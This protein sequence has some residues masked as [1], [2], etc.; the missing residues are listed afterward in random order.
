MNNIPAKLKILWLID[1]DYKAG[2][3][4]GGNLRYFNFSRELISKG[5]EVYFIFNENDPDNIEEKKKFLQILIEKKAVTDY[6]EIDYKHPRP[7]KDIICLHPIIANRLQQKKQKSMKD[8]IIK[9]IKNKKIDIFILSDRPFMFILPDIQGLSKIIIDWADSMTLYHLREII[10]NVKRYKLIT[11]IESLF[12]LIN[13]FVQERYYGTLCN[14]NLVVSPVDKKYL[15]YINREPQKNKVLYNGAEMNLS[16]NGITKIKNRIIFTGNMSFPPNKDAAIW[17][18]DNV[19]PLIRRK[20]SDIKLVIAGRNPSNE[21]LSRGNNYIEITGYVEDITQEIAKSELYVAPLIS[22]GGF[23]NKV[24]EAISSGTFV[25]STGIA[26]EF[27]SSNIQ[28]HLMIANRPKEFAN[29]VLY[30]LNNPEEISKKL[31]LLQKLIDVEFKWGRRT[32]ELINLAY[33]TS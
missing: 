22:G 12:S 26:S 15:D 31:N 18:I 5:H 1:L 11:M 3:Y 16:I 28:E 33:E 8:I 20:K 32:D 25:V 2:F 24:V 29:A 19:L 4:H 14:I 6:F 10:A 27:L 9:I 21:L 23:K 17:F 30:C 13:S 7:L